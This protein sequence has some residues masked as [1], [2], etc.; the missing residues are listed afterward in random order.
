MSY[1]KQR[2]FC[3]DCGDFVVIEKEKTGHVFHLL[4][5]AIT[6]LAWAL[7]WILVAA[8]KDWQCSVCASKRVRQ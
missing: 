3:E 8:N 5:T 4:M 6:F 7:V 2:G 1:I